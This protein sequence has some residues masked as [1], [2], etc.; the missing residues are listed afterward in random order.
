MNETIN[1][2]LENQRF[3]MLVD[4]KLSFVKYSLTDNGKTI[5]LSSTFVPLELR[6]QG[7]A[8]ELVK[9]ALSYAQTNYLQVI[10]SCSFVQGYI[11][12]HPIYQQ[13]LKS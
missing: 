7:I 8:D 3:T 9:M 6:G 2:D 13:L 1:H 12:R 11:A 10:S 4:D 5:N